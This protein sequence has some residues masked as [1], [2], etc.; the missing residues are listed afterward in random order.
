VRAALC[1]LAVSDSCTGCGLLSHSRWCSLPWW[2]AWLFVMSSKL[3]KGL[4]KSF[5]KVSNTWVDTRGD[6]MQA[7]DRRAF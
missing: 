3:G 4:N 2:V 7:A 6:A 1:L 5:Y